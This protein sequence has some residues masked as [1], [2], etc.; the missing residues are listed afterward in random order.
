[1]PSL[2]KKLHNFTSSTPIGDTELVSP[3]LDGIIAQGTST[4]KKT[5]VQSFHTIDE[6]GENF[7][8]PM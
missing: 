7:I 5:A 3:D 6:L 1:M 4:P 8:S 2:P